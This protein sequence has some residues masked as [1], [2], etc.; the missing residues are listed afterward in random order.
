MPEEK[1]VGQ[2]VAD[3]LDKPYEEVLVEDIIEEFKDEFQKGFDAAVENG[4]E[5]G[6]TYPFYIYIMQHK[7]FWAD[8]IVRNWYIARQ[9]PPHALDMIEKYPH[10]NKILYMVNP[11][12]NR[13]KI[14]WNIPGYEDL[15]SILKNPENLSPELVSWCKNAVAGLYEKDSYN[16]DE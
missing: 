16:F 3:I 1:T 5:Q 7:E 9:T 15:K 10:H 14:C 11:H 12:N 13:I 6:F 8:N 4:I 2:H